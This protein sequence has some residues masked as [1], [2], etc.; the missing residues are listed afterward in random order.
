MDELILNEKYKY[1]FDSENNMWRI[2]I[3]GKLF[4][5]VP[6]KLFKF[7]DTNLNNV[8]ALHES[9]F[10]L[11]NPSDFND[12]FDC[13]LN[14]IEYEDDTLRTANPSM[15]RNNIA[16]IGLT[17][18]TT[19]ID[20]PLLWAHY[21]KNYSGF[22]L[23]F[24]PQTIRIQKR[25]NKKFSLNPVLYFDT[26]IKVKNTDAYS[27]EYFLTAKSDRWE[28]E[29]EWRFISTIEIKNN[30]DRI[31]FYQPITVKAI[32]IGHRLFEEQE[33]VFNLIE[34]IFTSKYPNKPVYIVHPHPHKLELTFTKR[35]YSSE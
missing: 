18:F 30:I 35:D 33:S 26:F 2:Y 11:S 15:K 22:V 21:A 28:Y 24:N 9:Y 34:S 32:Y 29:K 6:D 23:E 4:P 16:N 14:L 7:Y 3:N 5:L 10:W 19:I 17:C 13:N 25:V 12:P 1:V 8:A 31:V 27:M 20:E